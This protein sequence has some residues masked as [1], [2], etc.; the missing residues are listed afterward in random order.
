MLVL[1]IY[2]IDINNNEIDSGDN[3]NDKM[4]FDDN[5]E[6]SVNVVVGDIQS[7]KEN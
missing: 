7:E 4:E 6:E 5:K 1:H 2:E 3:D